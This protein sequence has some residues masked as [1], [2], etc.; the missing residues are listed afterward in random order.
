LKVNEIAKPRKADTSLLAMVAMFLSLA[1]FLHFYSHDKI[2][3]YGDAVAHINIARRVFDS[4]FPGL[5]QL[6][7]VWLPLPHLLMLPFI[8][9]DKLWSTGIGG[10]II[11]L[12]AYVFGAVGIAKIFWTS[13]L[14]SSDGSAAIDTQVSGWIATFVYLLNPNLL[15]LQSTAMTEPL[16]LA[17]MVWAVYFYCRFVAEQRLALLETITEENSKTHGKASTKALLRCGAVLAPAMLT[18]YDYWFLAAILAIAV[19]FQLYI[20]HRD[21]T[22]VRYKQGVR[23][24]LRKSLV[25]FVLVLAVVPAFWLSYNQVLFGNAMEFANGKYSARAIAERSAQEGNPPHPGAGNLKVAASYYWKTVQLNVGNNKVAIVVVAV[26]LIGTIALAFSEF[27]LATVLL[28]PFLFYV[29]SIARGGIPIFVPQWWPFSYYNVRYGIQLLPAIA[30]GCGYFVYLVRQSWSSRAF[31]WAGAMLVVSAVGTAYAL[32]WKDG[33]VCLREAEINSAGRIALHKEISAELRHLP[34]EATFV[35]SLSEHVGVFERAAIPLRRTLNESSHRSG[36]QEFAFPLTRG[37]YVLA[38]DG[39]PVARMVAA[40]PEQVKP[41][42]IFHV[43]GEKR[44][45]LYQ[46]TRS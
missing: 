34:S 2:L 33:A 37:D 5:S 29:L 20:R 15:Y 14:F 1:A 39:D 36:E 23:Q 9:N 26:A 3:Q 19:V 11:S 46:V 4:Q 41:V 32:D 21:L 43:S 45:V 25:G 12:I 8:V 28:S 10:S 6:G 35:V 22:L 16:G 24:K 31:R 30:I 40:H 38:F 44:C 42:A 18:R 27:L 17:L 7:T 13:G